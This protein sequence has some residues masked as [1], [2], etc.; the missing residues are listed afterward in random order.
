[1]QSR[2]RKTIPAR[3]S[4][5]IERDHLYRHAA[6]SKEQARRPPLG[7]SERRKETL[8]SATPAKH[9]IFTVNRRLGPRFRN[10]LAGVIELVA[11]GNDLHLGLVEMLGVSL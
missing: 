6:S 8:R 10:N 3:P 2:M 5:P 11:A 1:M 4:S 9:P 7:S